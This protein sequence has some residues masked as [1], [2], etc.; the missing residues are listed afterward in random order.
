MYT[1]LENK[2]VLI[3]GASTGIGAEVT[4]KFAQQKAKVVI[5]YHSNKEKAEA[6]AKGITDAGGQA[7]TVQADVTNRQEVDELIQQTVQTYGGIDILINNAGSM[8]QRIPFEQLTE[9]TWNYVYDVNVKSVYYVTQSALPYLK[10]SAE[11]AVVNVASVAGRNGG[12]PG[13]IHYASAKGAVITLTKGLAKELIP[14]GIRVNGVNPG[15]IG[16][17]FHEKFSTPQ[18]R[19]GFVTGIPVGREGTPAEVANIITFLA[20]QEA[21]YLYG[22]IVEI[23]GAQLLD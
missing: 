19:E 8:V 21:S 6:L 12:G 7:I 18:I 20:S 13:A 4:K 9:E 10:D 17:P 16:T 15:V 5:N 1:C 22:E 2:V 11:A 3:T 14:Y 23:N